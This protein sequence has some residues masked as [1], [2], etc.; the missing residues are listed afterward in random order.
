MI[1]AESFYEDRDQLRIMENGELEP[2]L[3]IGLFLQTLDRLVRGLP[4]RTWARDPARGKRK[5]DMDRLIEPYPGEPVD[6]LGSESD[7]EVLRD[8]W[9]NHTRSHNDR[10]SENRRKPLDDAA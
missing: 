6:I 8:A 4:V 3:Q 10:E 1:H 9:N 7:L 2:K 5:L